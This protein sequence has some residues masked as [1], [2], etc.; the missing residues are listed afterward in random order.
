VRKGKPDI[1]I[2]GAKPEAI[3]SGPFAPE[4]C[5]SQK[6][7]PL[8]DDW[9]HET[10]WDGYRIVAAVADGKTRLWSRNAIEWTNKVP[11]LAAAIGTLKLKS[12][13]LDGEMVVFRGDRDDFNA[14]QSRLSAE[15]KEAAVYVLFDIPHLNG[16]SLR[17]VP[18]LQRKE[19]LKGLLE[20]HAHPLLR[21]SDY[22]IGRGKETLARA[23]KKG[24][25]GII[26]K[27]CA[28][29][30]RGDRNGDWVKVKMRP[31]DEFVVIGFTE[32][33][34]ARAGI[35]ALLLAKYLKGDLVYCGRVGTGF[36]DEQLRTLRKHL[37]KLVV[38]EPAANIQLM[39][40]KDRALAIWVKPELVLEAFHQGLGG[41]GLLR[42][43]AFKAI[44][45]DK[46][47][48]DL[49]KESLARKNLR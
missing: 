24:F 17:A 20:K 48:A 38:K 2:A 12:A 42:Q 16:Q 29:T 34:G 1:V 14:L 3:T 11:E 43:P 46:S 26:S 5:R 10:K 19:I 23:S 25:E 27:R 9:L 15:T 4:L 22:V 40:R 6:D 47:P 31:S 28:S 32:P 41:Q 33:K 13:Q 45:E 7:P 18:L 44:R 30:Y 35:G 21:F 49:K 39:A 8:G 36:K 37:S